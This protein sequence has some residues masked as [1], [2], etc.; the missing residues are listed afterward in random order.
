MSNF[1][2]ALNEFSYASTERGRAYY[3]EK[4]ILMMSYHNY[5]CNSEVSG[6]G[7]KVYHV[8]IKFNKKYQMTTNSCSC[9]VGYYCKHVAATLFALD[10]KAN[11]NELVLEEERINAKKSTWRVE[12]DKIF[13]KYFANRYRY[14]PSYDIILDFLKNNKELYEKEKIDTVAYLTKRLYEYRSTYYYD[15]QEIIG[16]LFHIYQDYLKDEE[17]VMMLDSLYKSDHRLFLRYFFEIFELT[18]Y[19]DI[20]NDYLATLLNKD[21]FKSLKVEAE[22]SLLLDYLSLNNIMNIALK[23]PELFN[24]YH[25]RD[26]YYKV[27]NQDINNLED[28]QYFYALVIIL[29]STNRLYDVE[30]TQLN[31]LKNYDISLYRDLLFRLIKDTKEAHYFALFINSFKGEMIDDNYLKELKRMNSKPFFIQIYLHEPVSLE[32]V[33]MHEIYDLITMFD[34][35]FRGYESYLIKTAI[36]TV[37]HDK[38][39]KGYDHN[40]GMALSILDILHYE[41]MTSLLMDKVVVEKLSEHHDE[42]YFALIYKYHLLEALGFKKYGTIN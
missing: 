30:D 39:L 40:L 36:K 7:D 32:Y 9:P 35:F 25:I 31:A 24:Y 28:A 5:E 12:L 29:L 22:G 37:N 19:Q 6:S 34:D 26:T 33:S 42:I 15:H 4:R 11:K 21:D 2:D 13:V 18:P 17:Y 41:D 20:N 1:Y 8:K 38:K 27:S 23:Y 3:K 14:S 10:E 16:V